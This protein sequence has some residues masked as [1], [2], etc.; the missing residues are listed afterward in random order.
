MENKLPYLVVMTGG[1]TEVFDVDH[2]EI[3]QIGVVVEYV[4]YDEA[5]EV[6][7]YGMLNQGTAYGSSVNPRI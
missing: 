3:N 6:I 1:Q 5:D 4:G 7:V 2:S